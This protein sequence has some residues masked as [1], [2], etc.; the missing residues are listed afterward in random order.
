M[1]KILFSLVA[2]VSLSFSIE[3]LGT[4][5]KTELVEG[6][7][8]SDEINERIEKLDIDVIKKELDE[9]QKAS[10]N[11]GNN[12]PTCLET[13]TREFEPSFVFKEDLL[14]PYNKQVLYSKDQ[15]VNILKQLD[16]VFPYYLLFADADD[17]IQR[18]LA[19]ALNGKAMIM[20]AN[21]NIGPFIEKKEQIYVARK[22]FEIKSFDIACVPSIVTQ[23][24]NKFIINEYKPEDLVEKD[25]K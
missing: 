21:G 22:E 3:D 13:K 16:I 12:L 10:Y 2:I 14:M 7:S 18:E 9:K 17:K 4:Y 1:K 6:K 24:G 5:G 19:Y 15:K 8:F 25:N 20:F 23:N 11:L